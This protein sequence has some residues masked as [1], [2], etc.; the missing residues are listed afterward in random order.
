MINGNDIALRN[1]EAQIPARILELVFGTDNN[2]PIHENIKKD[3]IY[4]T[5]LPDCNLAGGKVLQIELQKEWARPLPQDPYSLFEIPLEA[6]AGRNIVEVHEIS[7]KIGRGPGTFHDQVNMNGGSMGSA[8]L[9]LNCGS[10]NGQYMLEATSRMLASKTTGVGGGY[11]YPIPEVMGNMVKLHPSPT[12]FLPWTLTLRVCYDREMTNLNSSAID[13]YAAVCVVAT[14]RYCYNHLVIKLNAGFVEFGTELSSVKD[15]ISQWSD[16]T[17]L[18]EQYRI[19]FSQATTMD[20]RRFEG[21]V[22]DMI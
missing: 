8:N 7:Q 11:K 13:K 1:I 16:L 14:K 20:M 18:Y 17:E 22:R 4:K 2:A 21:L 12:Y 6:R 10:P 19:S 15:I 5:V 3:V 9:E